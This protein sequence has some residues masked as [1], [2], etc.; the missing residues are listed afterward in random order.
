MYNR[1]YSSYGS[2]PTIDS[3]VL[4]FYLTVISFKLIFDI[5]NDS[6]LLKLLCLK[7]QSSL[8]NE[9]MSRPHV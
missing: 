9:P 7:I 8:D 2:L 6:L 5:S 3:H 1:E 4:K